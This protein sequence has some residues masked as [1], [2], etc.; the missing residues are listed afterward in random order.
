MIRKHNGS[1]GGAL[2]HGQHIVRFLASRPEFVGIGLAT[3]QRLWN[4]FGDDLYKILGDGLVVRLAE[5]LPLTQ[6]EIICEAWQNQRLVTDTVVFFDEIGVDTRLAQKVAELWGDQAVEKLRQNPYRLL[7]VCSWRQVERAAALLGVTP[8]DRRRQIG[9]VEAA[10]YDRLDEKHTVSSEVEVL[11]RIQ[12]LL[13]VPREAAQ[14]ALA[15]AIEDGAAIPCSGGYQPA[16]AAYTE[17]FIENRLFMA[18]SSPVLQG[19]LFMNQTSSVAIDSFLYDYNLRAVH[20]LTEEQKRAV[21][22]ALSCRISILVGGAGVGKTTTLRAINEAARGSALQVYQLALSGRAAKR[23]ADATGRPAQTIASWLGAVAR[24]ALQTG[25]QTLLLVDEASMLDLPTLYRLLF[26]LHENARLV[27]VG[28]V[29]Q[30][31]PI[32]YGLTLHKLAQSERIPRVEL[33]RMLRAEEKTGIPLISQAIRT[34][35]PP[36]IPDYNSGSQG[37]AFVSCSQEN[38]VDAIEKV[39]DDLRGEDVQ[40][41]GAVYGGPAGIDAINTHFHRFNSHSRNR[42]GRFANDDPVIWTKNDYNLGL[43]N[44][45]MGHVVSANNNLLR[46][47]LDGNE[48]SIPRDQLKNCLDLAYAISTHKAQGSQWGS[49]IVPLVPSRLFDR[50][51]LYTAVTRAQRRVVL[52]GKRSLFEHTILTKP[53]SLDRDVALN[54]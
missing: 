14:D 19:Y 51:L 26:H 32:G 42:V 25:A 40:I 46:V 39:R 9:A 18:L 53:R 36:Q 37:V 29:A 33:T 13:G 8:T 23:I 38:M 17:R 31:A 49:V 28:D 2:P 27:L 48:Y 15:V 34:G 50:A 21:H 11:R 30:L 6:A 1:T 41:V 10:L 54:I 43:W 12:R 44:G 3:A 47:C 22:M 20:P 7:T 5:L 4:R 24:N 35:E 52:I 45:S 16:G